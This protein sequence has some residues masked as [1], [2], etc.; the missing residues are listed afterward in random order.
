M[1]SQHGSLWEERSIV[2]PKITIPAQH[3]DLH[4]LG[5]EIPA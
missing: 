3:C 2:A 5:P 4:D 1:F